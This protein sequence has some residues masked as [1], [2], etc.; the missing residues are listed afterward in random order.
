MTASAW[1]SSWGNHWGNSWGAPTAAVVVSARPRRTWEEIDEEIERQRPLT[2]T[3]WNKLKAAQRA[4][5]ERAAELQRQNKHKQAKQLS[6]VASA[7]ARAVLDAEEAHVD[8]TPSLT[9]LI[10]AL[11]AAASAKRITSQ[12]HTAN[13]RLAEFQAYLAGVEDEEETVLRL[14]HEAELA[15]YQVI[16][17]GLEKA[18]SGSKLQSETDLAKQKVAFDKLLAEINAPAAK[19]AAEQQERVDKKRERAK[20]AIEPI[21]RFSQHMQ[22]MQQAQDDMMTKHQEIIQTMIEQDN[23]PKRIV[24]DKSG[25]VMH[26]EVIKH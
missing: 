8:D 9:A 20:A 19:Q 23:L 14:S 22:V 13:I 16:V 17:A 1:G 4:A 10:G 6:R 21:R 3:Q 12:I 7:A 11:D 18:L 2:R 15:D 5:E 24:R 25:R 26:V